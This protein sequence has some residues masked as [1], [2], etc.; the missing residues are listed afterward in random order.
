MQG[1]WMAKT[2]L[3]RARSALGFWRLCGWDGR[4]SRLSQSTVDPS[5]S[6]HLIDRRNLPTWIIER[7]D[8]LL[9]ADVDGYSCGC[10]VLD[11]A[12]LSSFEEPDSSSTIRTFRHFNAP[13]TSY[14][15]MRYTLFR[16]LNMLSSDNDWSLLV[17]LPYWAVSCLSCPAGQRTP[18]LPQTFLCPTLVS[19]IDRFPS[20][21][22]SPKFFSIDDISYYLNILLPATPSAWTTTAPET[23]DQPSVCRCLKS[24]RS[25]PN[26]MMTLF[27]VYP[28]HVPPER[29]R[30]CEGALVP[31]GSAALNELEEFGSDG[32]M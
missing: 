28:S 32:L 18:T 30:G 5:S 10:T 14:R 3:G 2:K 12:V 29:L 31:W 20:L 11:S 1:N 22:P 21:T 7:I 16:T 6:Y 9:Y 27:I 25:S 24:R 26:F 4:S 8:I 17:P 13:F 15:V 23:K 19:S